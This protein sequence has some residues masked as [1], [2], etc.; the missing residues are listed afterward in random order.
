MSNSFNLLNKKISELAIS[1]FKEPTSIQEKTIPKI[2]QGKN[3][4][5]IAGTGF[6][7]TESAMLPIFSI[8]IEKK[9]K[10]ISILY[11]TP[12][13]ALNRDM[14]DRLLWWCEK[15]ELDASVRHGD[16]TAN[17]RKLQ[18]EYPP[19]LLIS[20]PEQLQAMLLGSKIRNLIKNLRFVIIDEV[21][22][23][24]NNKRGVQ[25]AVA[26]ERLKL[27][28]ENKPQ[29]IALSATIGDK[30]T[31]A[32]FIFGSSNDY[33]IVECLDEKQIK[34]T[35]DI[36]KEK[37][38]DANLSEKL[39]IGKSV[40]A[41]LRAIHDLIK[42]KQTLIFTNTRETAEVLASRLKTFN[43]IKVEVHHSS[44]SK[45]TRLKTEKD[46]KE[47]KLNAVIAT[48][49][50]ELGID[51]GS[52]EQI[53]QYNS[54]RQ[55]IKILQ[56]IGRAG[57]SKEKISEGIILSNESDDAFESAAI[58]KL[59]F[60]RN[61]EKIKPHFNCLDILCNQII[62]IISEYPEIEK[63]KVFNI[64]KSSFPYSQISKETFDDL[65]N[66]MNSLGYL[67]INGEK[68]KRKRK[69]LLHYYSSISTIPESKNYKVIDTVTNSFIGNL[70][71][72]FVISHCEQGQTFVLKGQ[73]WKVVSVEDEKIFV[74][75]IEDIES[76]IPAWEGELIPVPLEVVLEVKKLQ[77]KIEEMINLKKSKDETIDYLK[78]EYFLSE[79]A[80]EFIFKIISKNLENGFK[81][82]NKFEIE[83]F[84]N[85]VVL[86]SPYGN[87]INETISKYLSA[88]LSSDFGYTILSRSDPYRIIFS[89]G[90]INQETFINKLLF[91]LKNY[92][93]NDLENILK[94]SLPRSNMFKM[95]FLHNLKRFGIV[96]QDAQNTIKFIE[97]LIS[98]YENTPV[99]LETLREIFHEKFDIE[100]AE[101]ILME[102]SKEKI[103]IVNKISEITKL[104]MKRELN[105]VIKPERATMQ[106][107][108]LLKKRLNNTKVKLVC[109]NCGNWVVTRKV[110]EIEK[111]PRCQKCISRLLAITNYYDEN[112]QKIIKK[113]LSGKELNVHE[114]KLIEKYRISSDLTIVYGKLA[115]F[116]IAAR[117]VG[118]ETAKRILQKP[119]LSEEELL[120]NILA[121]ERNFVKNRR[122]WS[123]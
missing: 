108:E 2:L 100:N 47:R 81:C 89:H 121:E 43:D 60:K 14:L 65:I 59:A 113:W 97:K 53:I 77:K 26:L 5:V 119:N 98:I 95:K 105:E 101:N 32:K 66:F 10:P 93:K 19:H 94:I 103:I 104:G 9:Y 54:P 85:F 39:F 63:E 29:L 50:L 75:Y 118:P 86:N 106:I 83:T 55:V 42:N 71:E 109:M 111:E 82:S 52:I 92:R 3:V 48:S 49:S 36:I 87:K 41:K 15:L 62:G 122:F 67:F 11:I 18:T 110:E 91:Y 79:N 35:I 31:T 58:A 22:E 6:G 13:K 30:E 84:E 40:A 23:L 70:D 78:N 16:T 34:L 27:I 107:L 64:I 17:E 4:L 120:K 61:L 112:A 38:E 28:T 74:E 102:N 88:L 46:F 25:L 8:Q 12:L 21:H 57:H 45:E 80:A 114:K 24:V 72:E 7:K 116:V 96:K 76:Q 90:I 99:Y 20:T 115:A 117:G 51:I 73:T 44:L 56:R 33:E 123:E 1:R 37:K 68:L 69:A